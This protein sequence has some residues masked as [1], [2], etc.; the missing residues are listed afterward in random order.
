MHQSLKSLMLAS[1][2][3]V[4]AGCAGKPVLSTQSSSLPQQVELA[5]V[6]FFPQQEYQCGPA[7]LAT[8]LNQR[9]LRITPEQL[10]DA[11]YLPG[12]E[13]SLQVELVAAAR[14]Q[15]L[16]AYPLAPELD[17]L[18][19]EVAAGNP[20]LVLQNLGLALMP[21]WHFAVVVGYDI[22][23]QKL[24]LRS[25]TEKRLVT[26]F[27][28]FDSTWARSERW[29]LVTTQP[30]QL[31]ATAQPLPWLQ[32]A[33]DLQETGQ[34]AAAFTAMHTA[35]ERWPESSEA[36]FALG[37]RYY[38]DGNAGGAT[39]AFLQSIAA[40]PPLPAAWGNLAHVLAENGCVTEAGQ[41]RACAMQL[42]DDSR[43][44]DPLPSPQRHA[45]NCPQLVACP[46][47]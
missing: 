18:L 43:L 40:T 25:G 14:Q 7:A 20:V 35:V 16:L 32:S 41:A 11:V 9:G 30:Y 21:Q 4:L 10:R 24:L 31:P 1:T 28:T 23:G 44:A 33:L 37:N 13:G 19:A 12:R 47:S 17:A 8:V 36:W 6:P 2:L 45:A 5:S 22:A 15:G 38:E 39:G 34:R 46:Q 3:V 26:D 42:D 29:A 27:A